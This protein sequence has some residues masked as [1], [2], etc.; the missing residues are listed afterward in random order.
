LIQLLDLK[1]PE[2]YEDAQEYALTKL[3]QIENLKKELLTRYNVH[4]ENERGKGYVVAEP[5]LQVTECFEK[6]M[7]KAVSQ[8]KRANDIVTYVHEE[9]LSLQGQEQRLRNINKIAFLRAM[10]RKKELPGPAAVKKIA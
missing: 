10:S 1:E 4:L 5:E 8:L 2:R 6:R 3:S 7:K 9:L